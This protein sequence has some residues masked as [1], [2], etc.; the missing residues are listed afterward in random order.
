[1]VANNSLVPVRYGVGKGEVAEGHNRRKVHPDGTCEM[2]WRNE[3]R[4]PTEP[5][6]YMLGVIRFEKQDGKPLVTLVN[7]TCHPVIAGPENLDISADYPGVLTK[8]VEEALGGVCIFANGACGDINPFM[9]K[10]PPKD[11]AF[12]EI[13]LMGR[14]LADEVVR[15]SKAIQIHDTTDVQLTAETEQ[16]PMTM[17]W[18][19]NSPD[20][21]AAFEKKYGKFLVNLFMGRMKAETGGML[22]GDLVTV[23]LGDDLAIAGWPGEFFVQLGL[24]LKARCVI[25]NTFVFGYCNKTYGYFPTIN[26]AWQ[27]GYGAKEATFVEIGAGHKFLNETLA[28]FYYQTGRLRRVPKL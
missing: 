26:A 1:V 21:I 11:G 6:D 9:D 7:F 17:R 12:E 24:D 4:V 16:I 14:V 20:V 23:T 19:V 25:P 28:N 27:G 3:E 8:A 18:D 2:F 13:E 5:L 22:M 10:T 15:V